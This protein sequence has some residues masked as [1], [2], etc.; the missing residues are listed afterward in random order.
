LLLLLAYPLLLRFENINAAVTYG[1]LLVGAI[2][3]FFSVFGAQ[4][5]SPRARRSG[6]SDYE[7]V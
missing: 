6:V 7:P 5:R 4:A 3:S 1:A 2:A